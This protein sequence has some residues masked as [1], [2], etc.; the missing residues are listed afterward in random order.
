MPHRHSIITCW[1]SSTAVIVTIF[2]AGQTQDWWLS[3]ACD[4]GL[5]DHRS[6]SPPT[7]PILSSAGILYSSLQNRCS[8]EVNPL[9][10]QFSPRI[11]EAVDNSKLR[12]IRGFMDCGLVLTWYQS[13]YKILSQTPL[14]PG[15]P[16]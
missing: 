8:K 3:R 7:R 9:N 14:G 11:Y 10:T 4:R 15:F 2:R 16:I 13:G 6:R 12:I 1:S 5:C